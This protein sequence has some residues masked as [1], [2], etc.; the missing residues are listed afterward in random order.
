VIAAPHQTVTAGGVP[1]TLE[2]MSITPSSAKARLCLAAAGQSQDWKLVA[3]LDTGRTEVK[4]F[5]F[6]DLPPVYATEGNRSCTEIDFLAPYDQQPARWTLTVSRLQ[7]SP[8]Q[9]L[10]G[11]WVFDIPV[12][13]P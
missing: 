10:D 8:S 3:L 4:D 1:L 2:R 11:P 13:A 5:G 7:L 9:A 6:L 12:P